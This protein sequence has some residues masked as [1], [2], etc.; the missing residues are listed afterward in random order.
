MKLNE[1]KLRLFVSYLTEKKEMIATMESCTG[2]LLASAI[3]DIPGASKIFSNGWVTYT[4]HAKE[5][6]GVSK[7]IIS[8]YGVYSKE[9]AYE[10]AK[11]AAIASDATYGIG[12]TGTLDGNSKNN[13][14]Y[15]CI[16]H[17]KTKKT[18]YQTV[19][20]SLERRHDNKILIVNLIIELFFEF[21]RDV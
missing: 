12:I 1:E 14:V 9:T 19:S 5:M 18:H 11:V 2:G 13:V 8:T 6:C 16:Y 7:E 4:N 10:M 3:T 17:S 15:I 20:A 21:S